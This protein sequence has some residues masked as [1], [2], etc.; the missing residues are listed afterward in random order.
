ML[1]C[2]AASCFITMYINSKYQIEYN[3]IELKT[4][5]RKFSLLPHLYTFMLYC[6]FVD[7]IL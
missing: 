5:L 1:L 4:D 7:N 6:Y 2:A 3:I